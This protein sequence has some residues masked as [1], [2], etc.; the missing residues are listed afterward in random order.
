LTATAADLLSETPLRAEL[1]AAVRPHAQTGEAWTHLGGY[2]G[3]SVVL[4]CGKVVLKCFLHAAQTKWQRERSAYTLLQ[5]A[6]L[7]VP[8]LL[9]HGVLR[10]A[11]PWILVSR[12]PG[13]LGVEMIDGLAPRERVSLFAEAGALL[14]R[15]HTLPVDERWVD[16]P[17]TLAH[18][19]Y[20]R[21]LTRRVHTYSQAATS[22]AQAVDIARRWATDGLSHPP[23][24]LVCAHGD[25]SMRN[26][27]VH[28]QGPDWAISGLIDFER[29]EPGE[30]AA[31]LAR[32][33]LSCPDWRDPALHALLEAY[34]TLAPL[35]RRDRLLMHI[36]LIVLDASIWAQEQDPAYFTQLLG[37]VERLHADPSSLPSCLS[38]P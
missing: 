13:Q 35:P 37:Q 19:D 12:L 20:A 11:V 31:D 10:D 30:A 3:R 24:A 9:A 28:R 4:G 36:G 1:L 15:L 14:G 8:K 16:G 32:M 27:L 33:L 18:E 23:P 21:R 26:L 17:R 22:S 25:F 7:P 29:C 34:T 6:G 38:D 2:L 5:G